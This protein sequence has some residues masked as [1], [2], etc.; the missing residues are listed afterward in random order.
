MTGLGGGGPRVVTGQLYRVP[1]RHGKRFASEPPPGPVHRPARVAVMLAFAH[2]VQRAIDEGRIPDQAEVARRLGV[3]RARLTQILD[4]TLFA[5]DVQERIL[6]LE[7]VDG[8][9]PLGEKVLRSVVRSRSWR[10]QR[11]RWAA[12]EGERP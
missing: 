7:A 10:L 5:P 8:V 2:K 6:R 9:Q 12:G 11:A 1:R 3:S 4:L